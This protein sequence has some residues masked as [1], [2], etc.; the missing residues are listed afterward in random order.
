MKFH[1]L[2]NQAE[3]VRRGYNAPTSKMHIEVNVTKLDQA[4]RDVIADNLENGHDLARLGEIDSPTQE[5]LARRLDQI[6]K[7]GFRFK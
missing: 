2:V 7:E 6:L 4:Q 5:G 3:S 1:V